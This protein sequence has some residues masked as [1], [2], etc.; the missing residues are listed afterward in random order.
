MTFNC[1]RNCDRAM[2]SEQ[3][4]QVVEAILDGKYSWA[5]VLI[6]RF[7]GYNPLH[8]IPYR[9]YNRLMKEHR[10]KIQARSGQK[11]QMASQK[12]P[13]PIRDLNYI[14]SIEQKSPHVV[15]GIRNYLYLRYCFND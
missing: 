14:D 12:P 2:T 3:F 10:S 4:T 13:Q 15:G 8:Y 7:A 6:L 11:Q 1:D 9:T 5:C